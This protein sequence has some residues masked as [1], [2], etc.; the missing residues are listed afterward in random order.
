M[1]FFPGTVPTSPTPFAPSPQETATADEIYNRH[2]NQGLAPYA[3]SGTPDQPTP[4]VNAVKTGQMDALGPESN[5]DAAMQVNHN[6]PHV[7]MG[8]GGSGPVYLGTPEQNMAKLRGGDQDFTERLNGPDHVDLQAL[9]QGSMAQDDLLKQEM[10]K[11]GKLGQEAQEQTEHA[12][13]TD[14]ATAEEDAKKARAGAL[15]QDPFAPEHA[16]IAGEVAVAQAPGQQAQ[17]ND[18]QQK[19]MYDQLRPQAIAALEKTIPGFS[20]KAR[21]NPQAAEQMI[22][23]K[24]KEL[25]MPLDK[26]FSRYTYQERPPQFQ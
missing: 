12:A 13:G 6:A 24:V 20:M 22:Q 5:V 16:K 11:R 18:L 10:L 17:A 15:T 4:K 14:L 26:A 8:G 1:V 23:Q 7:S 3:L 21:Q 25:S 2:K 19:Q 9:T